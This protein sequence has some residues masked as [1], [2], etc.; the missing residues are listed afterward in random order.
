[1]VELRPCFNGS[2]SGF[3]FRYDGLELFLH[4]ERGGPIA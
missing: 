4:A 3:R 1:L 2:Q